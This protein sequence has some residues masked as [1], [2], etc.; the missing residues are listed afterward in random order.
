MGRKPTLSPQMVFRDQVRRVC[1]TFMA[2]FQVSES[3]MDWMN[4]DFWMNPGQFLSPGIW[5][6]K[7]VDLKR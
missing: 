7:V 2:V 4:L 1:S 3:D 6:F 5:K